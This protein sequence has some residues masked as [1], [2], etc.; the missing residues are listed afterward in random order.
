MTRTCRCF[1]GQKHATQQSTSRIGV[2]TRSWRTRHQEEAFTGV[3]PEVSHFRIFGCPVYIHVP[4]EKRTKLEPSNRKGLFVGYS[5]TSKAYKV[6]IPEQ[7]KTVVSRDVKFEEDF[8]SRKSHEPIPVTENEEQE[9]LKVEPGSPKS[10]SS[11]QQPSGEEE[12]TLAPSSSV[13]RPRWFTQT[14]RDAQE[15]VGAPRSTF[16]ESRPPKKFP[17]YMALM[18]NIIDSSLP[19][20]RRQQTNRFGGMP[21]WSTPPS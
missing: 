3:K 18:S 13:R 1:F 20:F 2:L 9:A 11:G 14:L 15:Y 17:N 21:W 19:V 4:V 16:R 5:E 8:A 6:Y 10:P 7:R 12:E